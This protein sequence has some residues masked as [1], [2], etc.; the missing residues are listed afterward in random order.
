M[1]LIKLC[2]GASSIEDLENWQQARLA[3]LV[4]ARQDAVIMH[5]TRQAPKKLEGLAQPASLYWIIR[6]LV[7]CRQTILELR[8]MV[9]EQ[10][11][12]R[13]GLCLAPQIIRVQ[14]QPRRP[15]QGWR[16][17]DVSDAPP[18]LDA[19]QTQQ[20]PLPTKISQHFQDLG[21]L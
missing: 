7:C 5:I 1:N 2:V 19:C 11:V 6:G 15:F 17:L 4:L 12:R 18:D 8:P 13:C 16:Y 9:D 3:A 14:P 10:G 21:L 20:E